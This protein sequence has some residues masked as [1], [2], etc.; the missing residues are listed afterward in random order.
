M[1]AWGFV[2]S[3]FRT[4]PL[5]VLD[6]VYIAVEWWAPSGATAINSTQTAISASVR[7]ICLNLRLCYMPSMMIS[8]RKQYHRFVNCGSNYVVISGHNDIVPNKGETEVFRYEDGSGHHPGYGSVFGVSG[9]A[10]R[11]CDRTADSHI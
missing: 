7:F 4:F 8:V 1:W 10:T 2:H 5:T 6:P 3:N 11:Q 9:A